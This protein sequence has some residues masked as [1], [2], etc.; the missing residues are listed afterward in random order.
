MPDRRVRDG[1]SGALTVTGAHA[2]TGAAAGQKSAIPAAPARYRTFFM[3]NYL[4][5]VPERLRAICDRD[6]MGASPFLVVAPCG[7]PGNENL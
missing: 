6:H 2:L 4:P 3:S 7:E 5:S 1:V